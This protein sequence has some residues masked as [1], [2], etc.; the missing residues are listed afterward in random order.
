QQHQPPQS[1]NA[2]LGHSEDFG[3]LPNGSGGFKRRNRHRS[4]GRDKRSR[5]ISVER[6][7]KDT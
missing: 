2:G 4:R 7:R 6:T 1:P 3:S 5:N